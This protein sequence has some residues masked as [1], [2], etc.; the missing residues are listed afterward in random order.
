[1]FGHGDMKHGSH[2]YSDVFNILFFHGPYGLPDFSES[3][4]YYYGSTSGASMYWFL[5]SNKDNKLLNQ[6]ETIDPELHQV[7]E[8][9]DEDGEPI[10]LIKFKLKHSYE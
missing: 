10:V 8:E 2:K 4:G 1:M 9:L 6:V 7:L 3:T 5:T